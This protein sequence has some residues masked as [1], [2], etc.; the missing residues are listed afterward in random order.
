MVATFVVVIQECTLKK[1]SRGAMSTT[2][3]WITEH[4]NILYYDKKEDQQFL[5]SLIQYCL[6][7]IKQ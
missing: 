6:C 4:E 7:S 2:S 5:F 3:G 1:S